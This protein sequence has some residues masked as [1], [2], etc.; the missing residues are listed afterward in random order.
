MK[1]NQTER[2]AV[3]QFNEASRL[4]ARTRFSAVHASLAKS[5]TTL[6]DVIKRNRKGTGS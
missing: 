5:K 1:R 6:A 2:F 4:I 3:D